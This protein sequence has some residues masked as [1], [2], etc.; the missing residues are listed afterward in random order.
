VQKKP[1]LGLVSLAWHTVPAG[2]LETHRTA[3][4]KI[5]P[6]A[7]DYRAV[8]S[9]NIHRRERCKYAAVRKIRLSRYEIADPQSRMC[10][11]WQQKT[12]QMTAAS[13]ITAPL[14]R[15]FYWSPGGYD[16]EAAAG[17]TG[18]G[19]QLLFR[20]ALDPVF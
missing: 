11:A 7:N 19:P 10:H 5:S 8:A 13:R 3:R 15:L 2:S 20:S 14:P 1:H 17:G 6:N 18:F 4:R 9:R 12:M 16:G